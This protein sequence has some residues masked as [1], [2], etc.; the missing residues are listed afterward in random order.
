MLSSAAPVLEASPPAIAGPRPPAPA[1]ATR[2]WNRR[3]RNGWSAWHVYGALAILAACVLIAGNAWA[4]MLTIGFKDEESS[5]VLLVPL[6]VAWLV[7]VRRG[8]L[9][10]CQPTGRW[11]GTLLLALGWFLWSFGYRQQV[12]SFWHSGAVL[13]AIGGLLTVTG[14]DLLV[15]FLPAFVVLVFLVP[16]PA[17][18]RHLIALPLQHATAQ[19]TQHVGE[20]LGMTVQRQ[21]NLLSVNGKEVAIV[22]ACNGMRLVFTLFLAC[23]VFAFVTP[24]RAYV[25]LIVLAASPLVAIV[26][27]VIRL[28]PTVWM[29]GHTSQR[30]A[31][32]FHTIA[33]WVMLA[34][35]FLGL[36]GIVRL[37][38]WALLP[39]AQFT[40][41]AS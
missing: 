16:V 27:N 7:W 3:W 28:V 21:G 18:G 5:H 9:R 33:G 10:S 32:D 31:Q 19:V 36:M 15:K 1:R 37:L 39:V 40:L 41:A 38:R 26:A 14:K 24:L 23:Y 4:D 34:V 35:A 29:F 17:T 12:Q 8:R 11:P 6:V 25:R 22:E 13:M 20:V 30:F 2:R